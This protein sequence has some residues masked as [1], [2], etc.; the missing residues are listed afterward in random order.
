VTVVT[1]SGVPAM[2]ATNAFDVIVNPVPELTGVTSTNGGFLLTWYAPTN[3]IFEVQF[4]DGLSPINWQSF[5]N[6]VTYSGPETPTNGL[7]S[8]FDDGTEHPFTGLRFYQVK[9]AGVI[10]PT[11]P[12]SGNTAPVLPAIGT[13]TVNPLNPLTVTNTATDSDTP[14]Q[15][16]TYS[17]NTT[18]TGTNQP[19]INPATGIITWTPDVSQAGTSNWFTTVVTDDGVPAMRATNAFA[20]MVNPVPD[21]TGVVATNGGVRLTWLAPTNDIFQV[22]FTDGL[23]PVNWQSFSNLVTYTGPQTPTNGLFSFFDDGTEHPFNGLRF[24]QVKLVGLV[25]P[26]NPPAVSTAFPISV[27]PSNG[28]FVLTWTASSTNQFK[29]LWTTN[30]SSPITWTPFADIITSSNG[31]FTFTDTN[32]P[33]ALK[34]YQLMLLP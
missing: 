27:V 29:V 23:N 30:I 18:V 24:Y 25:A 21:I 34:F 17:L 13:Q 31:T 6:L 19:V 33:A 11:N 26:T 10:L 20:V 22:Q 28:N 9:L 14:A 5:S 16:L 12:P 1:D 7:F 32:A 8:F 4:T 3:D 15:A 2:S